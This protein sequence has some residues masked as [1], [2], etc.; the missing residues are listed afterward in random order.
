MIGHPYDSER[1]Y[2]LNESYKNHIGFATARASAS[3]EWQV[4]TTT[5][6]TGTHFHISVHPC[7]TKTVTLICPKKKPDLQVLAF[8]PK[9]GKYPNLPK[10][11]IHKTNR[12]S[13]RATMGTYLKQSS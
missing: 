1:P 11:G 4:P 13:H 7:V 3:E 12:Y 8:T 5:R 2:R 9:V 10:Y 6:R